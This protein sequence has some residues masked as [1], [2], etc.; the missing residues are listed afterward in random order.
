MLELRWAGV[1]ATALLCGYANAP[2]IARAAGAPV[3]AACADPRLPPELL[4]GSV[5][6][7]SS[8]L[9]VVTGTAPHVKLRLAVAADESTRELG[10]M[11]VLRLRPR[12]GMIFVFPSSQEWEFWMK[13]TL[14]PLDM[15]WLADD[16]TITAVAAGVPASTRQTPDDQVARRRGSGRFVIELQAGEAALDALGVGTR[17]LLPALKAEPQ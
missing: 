12:A 11:C 16:G 14:A 8:P 7:P 4:D 3:V 9:P 2:A 13:D 1:L 5:P 15:L 6:A 17:V 10:L